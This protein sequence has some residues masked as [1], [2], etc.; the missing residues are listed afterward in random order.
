VEQKLTQ[1]LARYRHQWVTGGN[2]KPFSQSE[3]IVYEAGK[4]DGFLAGIDAITKEVH[5]FFAS[6][7]IDD[8]DL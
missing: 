2:L 4:R 3:N 6:Q 5:A 1:R 7:E 8:D